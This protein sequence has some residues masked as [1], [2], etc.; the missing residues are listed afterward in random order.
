MEYTK[1]KV[2]YMQHETDIQLPLD[3]V[4][5]NPDRETRTRIASANAECY[6]YTVV[7]DSRYCKKIGNT[8]ERDYY[9]FVKTRELMILER[10]GKNIT[11]T[12][13]HMWFALQILEIVSKIDIKFL[14]LRLELN[15][16]QSIRVSKLKKVDKMV[17]EAGSEAEAE[18]ERGGDHT[19]AVGDPAISSSRLEGNSDVLMD[20]CIFDPQL[21]HRLYA[22]A[23]SVV[24]T[25]GIAE[26][27]KYCYNDSLF[28]PV[29][30]PFNASSDGESTLSPFDEK[31]SLAQQLIMDHLSEDWHVCFFCNDD[32]T[33]RTVVP[34]E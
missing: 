32:Y 7:S 31:F 12:R 14:E 30:L 25:A 11:Y 34:L 15:K 18:G 27:V 28:V 1:L 22:N 13:Q 21:I 26:G 20:T 24:D 6:A 33:R 3:R 4:Y 8:T 17:P 23:K 10:H 9:Y 19:G 2:L 29:Q 16:F 5:V